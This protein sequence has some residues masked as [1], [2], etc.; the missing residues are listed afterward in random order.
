[1]YSGVVD[2]LKEALDDEEAVYIYGDPAYIG[3]FGILGAYVRR[4]ERPLAPHELAF[5]H[6]MS[7]VRIT[8]EQCFGGITN[9]WRQNSQRMR[10]GSSAVASHYMV[11]VL[12]ENMLVCLRG[13]NQVSDY[14]S[15]AP[16]TVEE[17]LAG[18]E[19]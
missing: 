3:S 8:I 12:L 9:R 18:L 14:F 4:P 2:L 19:M 17:Y 5:N 15:C 6:I 16:P 13:G 1:M 10:V 7:T 11:S